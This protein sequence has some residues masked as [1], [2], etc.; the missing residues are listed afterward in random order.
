VAGLHV[1]E[2]EAGLMGQFGRGNKGLS[3]GLK[4]DVGEQ[5]QVR[6]QSLMPFQ[7]G[8]SGDQLRGG[9]T[10]PSGQTAKAS[11]PQIILA[12]DRPKP[13]QRLRVDALGSPSGVP[14]QPSMG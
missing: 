8:I 5:R 14:S 6:R 12:V 9:F 4:F 1:H 13:R 3:D 10:R 2:V 11:P 7:G